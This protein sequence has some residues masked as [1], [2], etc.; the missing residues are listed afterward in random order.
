[1]TASQKLRDGVAVEFHGVAFSYADAEGNLFEPVLKGVNLSVARGQCV[2]VTGCSGCGKTTLMRLV[3]GLAPQ[4][5]DGELSG[6][7]RVLG[8]DAADL[9]IEGLSLCV[10]S[11][12]QNPRSQFFNLDTTSEIASGA[13]T[14]ACLDISH[15]LDRDIRKLSGGQRQMV[16]LASVHALGPEVFALDEPTAALDVASMRTLA[17]LV[18]RLKELGRT[19]IVSEHRLWWLRGIADRVVHMENGRIAHDWVAAEFERLSMREL[20]RMGLRAWCIEDACAEDVPT[21]KQDPSAP[22][23]APGA[24]S[25]AALSFSNLRAGYRRGGDVLRGA[26]GVFA[27]RRIAALVGGNG[28]GKSTLARCLAGLHRERAGQVAFGGRSVPYCR[29]AGRAFLV[30][31]EP[32]YQLFAHTAACELE[33]AAAR[34]LGRGKAARMAASEALDRFG[35]AHLAERHP[36]SLSGGERQ[37]LAIA[38]GV[39]QGARV[40]VLDEPTSGLDFANMQAVARELA[41]VRDGG[42]CVT[43]ITHD[44]EFIVAACDEVAVVADGRVSVQEPLARANLPAVRRMLGFDG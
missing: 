19:V 11:V 27:P 2:A 43:V 44:Y 24:A 3:N 36:L 23:P 12:F 31:Q 4:A 15:L 6:T 37:R 42:T 22:M 13:R 21:A 18:R 29:R 10:G 38:A 33:A 1:M 32:G 34:R 5:Y 39:L 40:L 26:A 28:A 30:M 7:V 9:G 41:R 20:H 14:R 16:A 17:H 25:A 8:Q 35:L